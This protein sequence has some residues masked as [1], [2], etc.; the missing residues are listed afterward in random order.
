MG[1]QTETVVY[2]YNLPSVWN[3]ILLT[4]L[5]VLIPL[6]FFWPALALSFPRRRESRLGGF[7]DSP[8]APDLKLWHRCLCLVLAYIF[9]VGPEVFHAVSQAAVQYGQISTAAWGADG[10]V[11]SYAYDENGSQVYKVHAEVT[12]IETMTPVDVA[13][14]LNQYPSVDFDRYDYNLQNRLATATKVRH[15]GTDVSEEI[16]QYA[17]DPAGIRTSAWMYTVIN[18]VTTNKQDETYTEYLVDPANHTGYTQV[19]EETKITYDNTTHAETSRQRLQYTLGDDVISQTKS[20]SI[21]SGV[22]WSTN[23]TQYLLYDGHGSTRQLLNTDLTVADAYSY[24]G[25]GVMLSDN[26]RP[27]ASAGT[28]LLY[29]GEQYDSSLDQYYLRAR[30]YNP[31]N[32][33]FNRVDPY[34]GNT[35]DPQS[36][37]KYAYCH[38]NPVNGIDPSGMSFNWGALGTYIHQRIGEMYDAE[39]IGSISYR[40]SIPGLSG[41][42]MPDI[43]DFALKEI[44]EIKPLSAYGFATGPIQLGGYLVVANSL[45]IPGAVDKMWT[46]STWDVGVREIPLPPYYAKS[47]IAVTIGNA[48]GLV[49]YK[50]FRIPDNKMKTVLL[51]GVIASLAD[52]LKNIAQQ[53]R[54][55]ARQ[56]YNNLEGNLAYFSQQ[57][58]AFFTLA[59][60]QSYGRYGM[61]VSTQYLIGGLLSMTGIAAISTRFGYI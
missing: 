25:Y 40:K 34:S 11:Y 17:Y 47:M 28:S 6:A 60:S 46:P 2:E 61:N 29:S 19:L 16:A 54:S 23:P 18:G 14:W 57:A 13:A 39:H 52:Q 27:E 33:T 15:V 1:Q 8:D 36:L 21:N 22:S 37:H 58:D 12:G 56:G 45:K 20:V 32:G 48:C 49:F 43:M 53:I 10:D 3:G 51:A 55:L 4:T 41:A 44:A 35:Q 59:Y 38:A 7:S 26:S 31:S 50:V 5:I 42:L 24:D 9:L 30:Y